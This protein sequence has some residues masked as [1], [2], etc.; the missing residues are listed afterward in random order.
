MTTVSQGNSPKQ[1]PNIVREAFLG[2]D[3]GKTAITIDLLMTLGYK[4]GQW[5][6][7]QECLN[8]CTAHTAIHII[9]DGLKH[10]T[11]KRKALPQSKPGRP[12]YAYQIPSIEELKNSL[13]VESSNVSDPLTLDDFQNQKSYRLAL[14]RELILRGYRDNDHLPKRFSRKF[15]SDRLNVS[16]E[17]LRSYENELETYI[18]PNWGHMQIKHKHDLLWLP[19]KRTHE[20]KW[21]EISIDGST[22][23]KLPAV[24]SIAGLYLKKGYDVALFW[25][26]CNSYAPY[27]RFSEQA[28]RDRHG[29]WAGIIKS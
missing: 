12:T 11:I 6:T 10:W 15:M 1:L 4:S 17:T 8:V 3:A 23:R 29:E 28:R 9:R 18:E 19:E 20:G 24:A 7:Y 5:L 13:T 27:S 22:A 26:E 25:R 16:P 2:I 21:L 14:H